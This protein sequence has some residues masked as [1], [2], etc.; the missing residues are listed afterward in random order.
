MFRFLTIGILLV[1]LT[2]LIFSSVLSKDTRGVDRSTTSTIKTHY[3]KDG[4]IVVNRVIRRFTFT[5]YLTENVLVPEQYRTLLLLEEFNSERNLRMEGEQ[6]KVKVEA[7][8]GKDANPTEK[9][10]TIEQA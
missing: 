3:D 10:W 7:W 2:V 9:L 4:N 6:S 8:I 1:S 5:E